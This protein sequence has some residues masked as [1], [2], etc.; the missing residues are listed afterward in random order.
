MKFL[1][2][3]LQTIK[4]YWY[5][6]VIFCL[7]AMVL[8]VGFIEN[9]KLAGVTN[10][11]KDIIASYK[12]QVK[13]VDNL[14]DKRASKDHQAE[15]TREEREKEIQEKRDADLAKVNVKKLQIVK[16]LKDQPSDDLAKKMKEE[17]KL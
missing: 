9:S 10:V 7:T 3:V 8:V 12:K 15:K 16:E 13:I 2:S 4:K 5:L 1:N 6:L 17:F 11:I 14:A